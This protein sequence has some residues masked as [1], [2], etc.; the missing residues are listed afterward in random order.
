MKAK[1]RADHVLYVYV[2]W[3]VIC[4]KFAIHNSFLDGALVSVNTLYT[5]YKFIV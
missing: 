2:I 1:V 4:D 5:V 3:F